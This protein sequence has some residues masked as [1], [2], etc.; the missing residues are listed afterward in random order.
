VL[1]RDT[2]KQYACTLQRS[3]PHVLA[4]ELNLQQSHRE[5]WGLLVLLLA[6][7]CHAN[8]IGPHFSCA[9]C[10]AEGGWHAYLD[11]KQPALNELRLV[12]KAW[13]ELGLGLGSATANYTWVKVRLSMC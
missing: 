5:K 7:T 4:S 9:A 11:S 10:R 2:C 12:T 3:T 1:G 13:L 8:R 6:I